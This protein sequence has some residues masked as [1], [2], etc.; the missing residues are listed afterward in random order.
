MWEGFLLPTISEVIY[1]GVKINGYRLDDGSI[2]TKDEALD[3]VR[4]GKIKN[5][6]AGVNEYGEKTIHLIPD[7]ECRK[8]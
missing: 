8:C 2:I 5:A 3:M 6:I 1:H 4:Q 7:M